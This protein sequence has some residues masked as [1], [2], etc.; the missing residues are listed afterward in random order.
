MPEQTCSSHATDLH[1]YRPPLSHPSIGIEKFTGVQTNI[2]N[3]RL[4]TSC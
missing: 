2:T 3:F 4:L 1:C